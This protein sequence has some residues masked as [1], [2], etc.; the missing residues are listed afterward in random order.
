MADDLSDR[1]KR[2]AEHFERMAQ[3]YAQLAAH[4]EQFADQWRHA[5]PD[6]HV[7]QG[8][9]ASSDKFSYEQHYGSAVREAKPILNGGKA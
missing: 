1:C 6:W 9:G 8:G 5:A 4:C 7:A 3:H 2:E